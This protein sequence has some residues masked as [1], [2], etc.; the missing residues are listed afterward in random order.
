MLS[1]EVRV[2][3]REMG[4]FPTDEDGHRRKDANPF[5]EI[6]P[7]SESPTETE[8]NRLTA[9][10][11]AYRECFGDAA[12]IRTFWGVMANTITLWKSKGAWRMRRMTWTDKGEW[13]PTPNGVSIE[14]LFLKVARGMTA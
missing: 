3:L 1:D 10:T 5:F 8:L 6:R 7:D 9:L 12:T 14:E 13:T 11:E 2:R 4:V